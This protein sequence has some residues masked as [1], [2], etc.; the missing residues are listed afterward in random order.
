MGTFTAIG[1][2]GSLFGTNDFYGEIRLEATRDVP[3]NKFTLSITGARAYTK[4]S[5]NTD[6]SFSCWIGN[7]RAGSGAVPGS[8]T[9]PRSGSNAYSGWLPV[10]G[11]YTNVSGCE[12]R[13]DGNKADGTC[14]PVYVYF[15]FK[16]GNVWWIS[17][18]KYTSTTSEYLGDLSRNTQSYSGGQID[19]LS[20]YFVQGYPTVHPTNESTSN[21]VCQV[22]TRSND[23]YTTVITNLT[24]NSSTHNDGHPSNDIIRGTISTQVGAINTIKFVS[25]KDTNKKNTTAHF[26]VD[27]R[28]PDIT[29]TL[30]PSGRNSAQGYVLT[31]NYD[32]KYKVDSGTFSGT[33]SK[34]VATPITLNNLPNTLQEHTCQT[35]RADAL[36]YSQIHKVRLDM[37]LPT[38]SKYKVIATSATTG[39]LSFRCDLPGVAKWYDSSGALLKSWKISNTSDVV[40]YT[41]PMNRATQSTY[42]L[43]VERTK[44]AVLSTSINITGDTRTNTANIVDVKASGTTIEVTVNVVG[45][46]KETPSAK[47]LSRSTGTSDSS[48]VEGV[49]TG[50]NTYRFIFNN[51]DINV[52]YKLEVQIVNKNSNLVSV[53]SLDDERLICKGLLYVYDGKSW[54][55]GVVNIY[56]NVD[57]GWKS[58]APYVYVEG[59]GWTYGKLK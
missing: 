13:F 7:D 53:I 17:K 54:R 48:T 20:P 18:G 45:G 47:L 55:L 11:G 33:Y 35:C 5:L 15:V 58:C 19:V 22:N 26:N 24:N 6:I 46:T 2:Y 10:S 57:I 52:L 44:Y 37:G 29:F 32:Y 9:I 36:I 41:V 27:C 25:T 38:L 1:N 14:P 23:T 31:T 49:L 51:V 28:R 59:S 42:T 30:E 43:T 8:C 12:K 21:Y 56:R 39:A 16:T 50:E 34:N 40:T 3:S 4:Y